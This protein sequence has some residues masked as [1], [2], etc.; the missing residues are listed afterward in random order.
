MTGFFL[1]HGLTSIVSPTPAVSGASLLWGIINFKYS[2]GLANFL[3]YYA[4]YMIAAPFILYALYKKY[5]PAV[6]L[7]SIGIYLFSAPYPLHLVNFGIYSWFGIWQLYF[8]LGMAIARFRAQIV[9]RITS[10]KG[11]K[12]RVGY[13]TV[14]WVALSAMAL[15]A[16]SGFDYFD[17]ILESLTRDG[18]VPYKL[19]DAY[20]RLQIEKPGLEQWLMNSRTGVLRPI[21]ALLVLGAG[22]LF[23][24]KHKVKL[25]A[26]TGRFVTAMGR[27]TLWIFVAQAFVIPIMA[28]LPIRH[29]LITNTLMTAVLTGSMWSITKRRTIWAYAQAYF[30]E[31]KGSYSTAKYNYL[32]Q[33]EDVN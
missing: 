11:L 21:I 19:W 18:W 26:Y 25:L 8:V 29:D 5:W 17:R 10:L 27:D 15:S 2:L 31:L 1:I 33:Y 4:V 12:A 13:R 22:Y 9:S 30:V 28:S 3:E 6:V 20:L 16:V 14:T 32:R 24:Q 7:T 23:Y